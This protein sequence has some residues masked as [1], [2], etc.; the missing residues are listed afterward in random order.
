MGSADEIPRDRSSRRN[1]HFHDARRPE[2]AVG[3]LILDQQSLVT[4]AD[5]LVM[6]E[7][8]II[9]SHPYEVRHRASAGGLVI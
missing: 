7:I 9:S 5:F 4:K 2:E 3:G 6:L 1:V 8:L